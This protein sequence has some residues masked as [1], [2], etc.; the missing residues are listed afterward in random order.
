MYDQV[1]LVGENGP[2]RVALP[3]GSK[4]YTSGTGPS[5]GGGGAQFNI[6]MP[7]PQGFFIGTVAELAKA[8]NTQ[9][10]GGL[11]NGVISKTELRAA[12]GL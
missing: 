10:I 7:A 2:E 6:T 5:G 1:A 8:M 12:L 3:G 9:L 11:R 4:V